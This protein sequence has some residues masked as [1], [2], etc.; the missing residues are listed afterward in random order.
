M[1]LI[2]E[3]AHTSIHQVLSVAAGP[4][5]AFPLL[6]STSRSRPNAMRTFLMCYKRMA[7][8][9]RYR[10]LCSVGP[11]LVLATAGTAK[12]PTQSFSVHPMTTQRTTPQPKLPEATTGRGFSLN[13][14]RRA[15]HGVKG[16]LLSGSLK[17]S[18]RLPKQFSDE[19]RLI[20]QC[21]G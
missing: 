6:N 11:M 4:A 21:S 15:S 8:L 10:V 2:C 12:K 20:L 7:L 13:L 19:C 1:P 9:L 17:T 14:Q 16:P 5:E 3:R 18:T